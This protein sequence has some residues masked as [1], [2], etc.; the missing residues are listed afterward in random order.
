MNSLHGIIM[1][2][3]GL[4]LKRLLSIA[5]S[6]FFSAAQ[7]FSQSNPIT[8]EN[9]LTGSPSSEW[10]I[11]GNGDLTIQGFATPFSINTG[12]TVS[13]KIDVD[14][15]VQYSIKIYRLGFYGGTGAR[16]I[17]DLGNFTGIAQPDPLYQEETGMTSCANWSVSASWTAYDEGRGI[18]AVSGIYIAR[19]TRSD[20]QGASH[21]V[22]IVRDDAA[23][24]DIL[25]K[26]ADGTWQAY[27][28]YGGNN[29]YSEGRN[30]PDF[31]HAVKASYDRPFYTRGGSDWG[32]DAG[33]WL[34]NAEYPMV[35]WLERNGYYVTYTTH[36][37]MG[38]N[39]MSITPSNHKMLMSVG[40][41]EYW[42]AT[43]RT[44][45][46]TARANGVHLA[47]FS[48]NE[49]YWKTRWE[50][51]PLYG[52]VMVCYKE[53]TMGENTCGVK[54][55]P[56]TVWT[57]L[58]RATPLA[59]ATGT[60]QPENALTGQISWL[61]VVSSIQVPSEYRNLR[62][63]RNTSVASLADGQ[64]ATM[65]YGTLGYEMDWEQYF[66]YYPAGRVTMSRTVEGG[67]THKLSLYRY[68]PSN[69]LVFGAG[70]VQWSW[71]LDG[72]HD[73]LTAT[74]SLA[75]QQ[76]TLNLLAD[77]GVAPATRQSDLI[78]P[79]EPADL[80][81]P[82]SVITVP[83]EGATFN[84]GTPVIITGTASDA[85]GGVVAGVDVS[86]DGGLTWQTATGS[87]NWTFVW[88]P[89]I[90]GSVTVKSRAFDDSGN[91]E[92]LETADNS[93]TCTIGPMVVPDCPCSIWSTLTVPGNPSEADAN[94]YELG[95]KF[96]SNTDGYIT[97][98]R[99]YKGSQNT[100]THIGNLWTAGGVNLARATFVNETASGWQ[101]VSFGTP[102][103]ITAGVTYVA[104]YHC[105]DGHYAED[106]GYFTTGNAPLY[107]SYY[108][109][110]LTD[111]V[112]APNGVY[113]RSATTTFPS[114]GFVQSNYWV[115]VVFALEVGPDETPPTVLNVSPSSGASGI[116]VSVAP[117]AT[118]NEW[119]DPSSV[120]T[121]TVLMTG[122]GATPVT[123]TVTLNG[124]QVTFTPSSQL[125]YSTTY[126]VI[127][128]GSSAG[129]QDMAGNDLAADYS[130]SFTT[131]APPPPP[132]TEG[133][134][135]PILVIS[136]A[137]NPFSR[138][139]VEILRA[140]GLNEFYA[141]DVSEVMAE[142]DVTDFIDNYDVIILGEFPLTDQFVTDIEAWVNGGGLLIAFRP[143]TRLS[144]LLGITPA[145]GTLSD[146]YLLV[147]TASGPGTGIVGETIQFHSAAD[148]YTLNGAT[149][150]A[151]LYSTATAA[152]AYPAV[153]ER[154]VGTNGGKAYA[155]TYDLPRSVVYTHQGNPAWAGQKRDG[156][157]NP[158]R[159]DDM[160]YGAATFDPQPD[161]IDLNKVA[162]PQADEQQ[163]LMANIIIKGSMHRTILPR[164][165]FLP[166]G[167]KAAV[168]M[169][170]D[171]HGDTGM[172]PRFIQDMAMSPSGCSVDDWECV[173]ST[174]YFFIGSTFTNDDAIY[175]N[176]LGFEAALHI[177]TNCADF[178]PA[179]YESFVSSQMAAFRSTFPG[180]PEPSTNRNHCIA[181][182]DWSTVP[183]VSL[184]H[185][186]R[187]DVNYYYWPNDWHLNRPGMFTGSGNPMRFAKLDGTIIDVYQV[188]TQ[189]QDEGQYAPVTPYPAYC[190]A[191]FDKA[192]GPE[193]YYGVFCANM[194][195]DIHNHPGANAITASAQARGIP[196]VSSKQMLTWLDGRNGS[197]FNN[198]DWTDNVL[199]F[200]ITVGAGANNLRAM[201]PVHSANGEL[202]TLTMGGSGL[203]YTTEVIKGI[204]YAF[205][206][207]ADGTYEAAYG[208]DDIAPVISAVQA[209]PNANGTAV[210]TWTTDESSTSRVDYGTASGTLD[211]NSGNATMVTSHSVTL[212]GL[213]PQTTYYYRVTS[214]DDASNSGSFP[215]APAEN[216]FTMPAGICAQ[217]VTYADFSLGVPD[218][219]TQAVAEGDGAVILKPGYVEDFSG[220]SLPSGWGSGNGSPWTGG[221][222]TFTGGQ[223]VVDGSHVYSFASYGPGSSLEFVATFEAGAYQNIGFS[224][225]A[226]FAAPW[227]VIGRGSLTD[228]NLYA[229]SY[230]NGIATDILLGSNLLSSAHNYR[231]KWNTGNFEFYVD[232]VL[233]TTINTPVSSNMVLQVSDVNTGGAV[234]SLDWIRTTPYLPSGS[235]TSRIFDGGG[236]RIWGEAAW[237]SDLP[238]GTSLSIFFRTGET[239]V[240][241]GSWTPFVQIA[242]SGSVVGLTS[243]FIQYRADLSTTNTLF[244]PVLRDVSVTCTGAS[245][246]PP[247]ISVHPQSASGCAGSNISFTSVATGVPAPGVHWQVST[248]GTDWADI[249]GAVTS[250][251]TF[252]A[253]TGDNGKQY[254]AVWSNSEGT[255]ISSPATL[256][257][258]TGITAA[259]EA[260]DYEVCEG[261][262]I[263]LRLSSSTTGQAPFTVTVNGTEYVS[264]G[265]GA[266][267]A[268]LS[269]SEQHIFTSQVPV[270]ANANDNQPGGI[271]LG[272]KFRSAV[273]GFIKGI[274]FY[275]GIYT[276]G[277]YTGNLW[278]STGTLL[279]SAVFTNVTASGW[280][281]VRFSSPVPILANTT[282]VASYHSSSGYFAI[283][284]SG[285]AGAVVNGP[286]TALA[287]G[288][289]GPNG[290]FRYGATGFPN[291]SR[292]SN[293]DYFAD[294]VFSEAGSAG[295]ELT[296]N[297]TNVTDNNGCSVTG[298]PVS[299]ATVTV[300]PLPAGAIEPVQASVYEGEDYSL[301]FNATAGTG[302]FSLVINGVT[303]PGVSDGTAFE[304]GTAS[305]TLL[306]I[307]PPATEVNSTNDYDRGA[308]E[309]G[310]RFSSSEAG[311]INAIRVYKTG[312]LAY[313]FTV[314][315][316]DAT[317]QAAVGTAISAVD[318]IAGWKQI[319][320]ATPVPIVAGRTYI[321]SYYAP[322]GVYEYAYNSPGT[323]PDPAPLTAYG[324]SYRADHTHG[325]PSADHPSANYWVDV[326]YD[327]GNAGST[328][329]HMTSVTSASGCTL[330]GNPISSASVT[331]NRSRVWT[332]GGADTQWSTSG[333]WSAGLVPSSDE[334]V[335]IPEVATHYPSVS[336]P[337]TTGAL[338][339][340]PSASMTV[341]AGGALTVNGE[342]RTT[343]ATMAINSTA[344]N[345]SGS[346][347]V[348]GTATGNVTYSRVMPGDLYRYVS[349]PV[350]STTLPAGTVFWKW[351]EEIGYWGDTPAEEPV[352]TGETGR[353]YTMLATGS[354]VSFTGE[355][356]TSSVSVT[357]TAPYG[358][359]YV[360]SRDEWGGGGWNLLGNPYPSA[361][362]IVDSDGTAENDFIHHNLFSFDPSYQAV[363]IYDGADYDYIA[364]GIPGYT[365]GIGVFGSN[366]IQAGQGFFVLTHYNGLPFTFMPGMRTHNTTTVMTKSGSVPW[367]G[368]Q[369]K[370]KT[371]SV[372]TSTLIAYG[373]GMSAG[374]DPGYDVG[375]LSSGAD[376]E[377]YSVL[378]GGGSDYN[379][380]RQA[381]PVTEAGSLAVP[382]GVD[383]PGGGEVTFTAFTIPLEG[384][385][386][387]LEDRVA[388]TYTDLNTKSY[389]VTL[390]ANTYGTGR[391]YIIAS[392]NTPTGIDQHETDD[393]GLRIWSSGGRVIIQG[394]VSEGSLCGIYKM[395][396]TKLLDR[397]LTGG[398]MNTVELIPGTNGVIIVRITD[399]IKVTTRKLAVI[400]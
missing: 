306:S 334:N 182:S 55:D 283:T 101:E 110:A 212:S 313:T 85:G 333:N 342:L 142:P 118:F 83:A 14:P 82:S 232:G 385:K 44:N 50:D 249:S 27:N 246:G 17:D 98:I 39:V 335:V 170:G 22:F 266:V 276:T 387:W 123:G 160:Y 269:T 157:I 206:T 36:V 104:S 59:P 192:I 148:L 37:D 30:I 314:T 304:A 179:Q 330:S 99:F 298:T 381:L 144:T 278:S 177:N 53:G 290:V 74:P 352:T 166:K 128:S 136:S 199:S 15:A 33:N 382:V 384:K 91:I 364:L 111:D 216:S 395:N 185:G 64:T 194:H 146:A 220:P 234:L 41:D 21:I 251:Y 261:E 301:V 256:T 318:A 208:V 379:F 198:I 20:T 1:P 354:G 312:S 397:K 183:E 102:V 393:G 338:I 359:D 241:D 195:F 4:G 126:T 120:N 300:N 294:V 158:I 248:N 193:G 284:A 347:I 281:E 233:I 224:H 362:R 239:A 244:T 377:I 171:N 52:K 231:I 267:F 380:A 113:T 96:R 56:T 287:A 76:A 277:T 288:T 75:M 271:E 7:V 107:T 79:T 209:V 88:T 164:F 92:T 214:A 133:P 109:S 89:A 6:V 344:V 131:S 172:E 48:G 153:T 188:V 274:R 63:W 265:A 207:A 259:L 345:S 81:K 31:T 336:G 71:G 399:G 156:K 40:H 293:A 201:L 86:V 372:E 2:A 180:V 227:V 240:P 343:D 325:Y 315:L 34:F 178:T 97:G 130:W 358:S 350:V 26:T 253:L 173:R 127:I 42:S 390:P 154:L 328:T 181:W 366:D 151:M 115:D 28:E 8:S 94:A 93:S 167:L 235:F 324:C 320:F 73:G 331:V 250:T 161:W 117:V 245:E 341:N 349:S 80:A 65:P 202:L 200:S 236:Q 368:V 163:R 77:M 386:F 222:Y 258:L 43:A 285:L 47:F 35:R 226:E 143:D 67:R 19:L 391:F 369:L 378:A 254:R 9:A 243:R 10:D 114:S 316:W 125:L 262:S 149:A 103:P 141:M 68:Q 238:E 323:F 186:I 329:F 38:N 16:M 260:V 204:E 322:G 121:S 159:S 348:N 279:A 257:V 337:L 263:A 119:L 129:I 51:D 273:P 305:Y 169:G 280:Q 221:S 203:P 270:Q 376:I 100:G 340:R 255:V 122:P 398:E 150:L 392:V 90:Q 145:A 375:H 332:G 84:A 210:I 132:P 373:S 302:P 272:V 213:L 152:T 363:Y 87:S 295:S 187:L 70:T 292:S 400:R 299:S 321:A 45:F 135:G 286:L 105:P 60:A 371:G 388:R 140:E 217:D 66:E 351:N 175:Y 291:D 23:A 108:L 165:W 394:E 189:M 303:Y 339:I 62:F 112:S 49:V 147:N 229:R 61:P 11:T 95:V 353:G 3:P 139:T 197:E 24:S 365:E 228:N 247:V 389:T 106:G 184:A 138:Y 383:F 5:F 191:L 310:L 13:F 326:V 116:S 252:T 275:N 211:L 215:V 205:F 370:V 168:V 46:E 219:N 361:L 174:G 196:V 162:I 268:N 54:C 317:T 137:T 72:N 319:N 360:K 355:V 327:N 307:W 374:L 78:T 356:L 12:E 296:Y 218:A 225:D 242:S 29:F 134:G 124:S 237:N 311:Y 282:Y 32:T 357:A 58:W 289:D 190:D 264:S 309:L 176:S 297:L 18:N 69:A 346:L 223:I 367:P 308:Y 57:G 396:G 155:F 230:I 25:F